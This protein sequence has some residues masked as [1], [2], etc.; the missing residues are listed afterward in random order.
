MVRKEGGVW[1]FFRAALDCYHGTSASF[2]C[3]M[4]SSLIIISAMIALNLCYLSVI[5]HYFNLSVFQFCTTL[6]YIF[7]VNICKIGIDIIGPLPEPKTENTYI[8]TLIDY[9]SKWPEREAL[10][11][12]D[13]DIKTTCR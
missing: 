5:C 3:G 6:S 9:F 8:V 13:A 2:R 12:K 10:A 1:G 4:Y 7:A 11:N